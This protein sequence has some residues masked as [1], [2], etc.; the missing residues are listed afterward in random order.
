MTSDN[1]RAHPRRAQTARVIEVGELDRARGG[2]SLRVTLGYVV[3]KPGLLLGVVILA[4]VSFTAVFD[5]LVRP[6]DPLELSVGPRLAPP[7]LRHLAGTDNFGRDILSRLIDASRVSMTVSSLAAL[8]ACSIGVPLGLMAGYL[9][10]RVDAIIMRLVD[11]MLAFPGLLFAILMASFLGHTTVHLAIFIGIR[12]VSGY[13]R[14]TRGQT[15]ATKEMDFVEASRAIGAR[16][17]R[18]LR[19]AI[20]PNILDPILVATSMTMG[21][22]L[23]I[24]ASLSF[25]GLGVQV[26]AP[27]WGSM[28]HSAQLYASQAPWYVLAPGACIT[29]TV[30][31]FNMVGDGLRD[32][33]D[34]RLRR[35]RT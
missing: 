25:L 30:L 23:L 3:R 7:S 12:S 35:I 15:L 14:L 17:A 26:P 28:L 9:G 10:G 20:L 19:T 4:I 6:Y 29:I 2:S 16:S 27:A 32:L 8:I 13:A 22:T 34:P 5:P 1:T 33:L 24:E 18:I 31:A 21:T 11:A